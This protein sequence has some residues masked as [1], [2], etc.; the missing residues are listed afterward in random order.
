MFLCVF[1]SRCYV[2]GVFMFCDYRGVRDDFIV[3]L[4]CILYVLGAPNVLNE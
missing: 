3:A 4:L 2:S 1:M